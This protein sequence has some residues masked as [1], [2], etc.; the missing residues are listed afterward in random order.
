MIVT[1]RA[2]V[3]GIVVMVNETEFCPEGTV[4]VSG[5]CAMVRLSDCTVNVTPAAG[6]A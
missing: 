2:T 6:A 3:T 4:T 1:V 5:G